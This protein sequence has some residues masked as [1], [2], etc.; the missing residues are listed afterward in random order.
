MA[1][2][3]G[4]AEMWRW[5]S[6]LAAIGLVALTTLTVPSAQAS[7]LPGKSII[8]LG[9]LGH[10]VGETPWKLLKDQLTMRGFP[11]SEV[12][13]FQYTGGTFG[14]DGSYTPNPGGKCESYSKASFLAL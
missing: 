14:P 3:H 4:G 2:A 5:I 10:D 9:S 7:H 13:E 11:E 12:L 8:L 6:T 1:Q